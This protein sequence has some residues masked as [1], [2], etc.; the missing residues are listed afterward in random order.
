M[1]EFDEAAALAAEQKLIENTDNSARPDDGDQ[2]EV[3]DH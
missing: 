2:P 1:S 3:E